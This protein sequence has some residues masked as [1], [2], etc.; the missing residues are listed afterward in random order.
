MG[1][2]PARVQHSNVCLRNRRVALAKLVAN[3]SNGVVEWF[4][5]EEEANAE[6]KHIFAL[7]DCLI[8]KPRILQCLFCHRGNIGSEDIEILNAEFF[9][10]V[11]CF[12]ARPC[13]AL[14]VERVAIN[15]DGCI[16][17]E[18]HHIGFERSG[19]HRNQ[20]IAI[21]TGGEHT[22]AA[23]VNLKTG[24][25][26]DSALWRTD[27]GRVIG[28]GGDTVTKKSGGVREQS[29][30]ELHTIARVARETDNNIFQLF[31]IHNV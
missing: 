27:F 5:V 11:R 28:E 10:G 29:A 15:D 25:T 14:V 23:E 26:S 2:V 13:N 16:L 4:V 31:Y 12:E 3:I 18:P 7:N 20:R 8:V 1:V 21:I 17:F 6:R 19:I 9:E 30:C 24:N 22:A